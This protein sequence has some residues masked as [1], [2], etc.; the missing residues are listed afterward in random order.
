MLNQNPFVY[1]SKLSPVKFTVGFQTKRNNSP[2][3]LWWIG[4]GFKD[5]AKVRAEP[6]EFDTREEAEDCVR[7]KLLQF[8]RDYR[9]DQTEFISGW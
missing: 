7:T 4:S 1:E 8:I 5:L 2:E 3:P 9:Q 6:E